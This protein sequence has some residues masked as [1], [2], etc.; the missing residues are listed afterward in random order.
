MVF[1]FLKPYKRQLILGPMAKL[2]EAVF[3]LFTPLLMASLIDKGVA[4]QDSGHVLRMSALIGV[5]SLVGFLCAAFCQYSASVA[6]QG[7]GT[8]LRNG[9]MKK[10]GLLN[11]K[12]MAEI[13]SVSVVNRL[14]GDVNQLQ[15]A[16]AMF[17]RLVVRA[18][19][20]CV[21][22]LIMA[23][24]MDV[25][26]SVILWVF[27]PLF[28][29]LLI[30]ITVKTIPMYQ[31]V[32]GR[33]D[34]LSGILKENITGVRV[35]R[36]FAMSKREEERFSKENDGWLFDS[37]KA[38]RL[39]ALLSPA[40][41]LIMNA[42]SLL[43][44]YFGGFHVEGG[45]LTQGQLIAFLSYV[46]QIMLAMIV[47]SNLAVLFHKAFAS[48]KRVE[49]LMAMEPSMAYGAGAQAKGSAVV[50]ENV[51][52]RYGEGAEPAVENVSFTV[53]EGA[54]VGIIGGTGAGKSSLLNL[55]PRLYDPF[56]GS[57]F[58]GGAEVKEYTREQLLEKVALVPQK[59]ALFSGTVLSNIRQGKPDATQEA[60][61]K[62]AEIAQA[63]EFIDRLPEKYNSPVSPGGANF[64][65]GQKQRLALARGLVGEKEVLIL[66]DS[67]SALDYA[68]D[69]SLR[70]AIREHIKATVFIA[71]QRISSVMQA[72]TILVM[73]DGRLV[74]HGSHGELLHNCPVYMDICKSQGMG[75]EGA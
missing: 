17:I 71:S 28:I 43:I 65:G 18:P 13:G 48:L 14:T 34:A 25:K 7:F 38:G 29:L 55:I 24:V 42:A 11:V 73:D 35:V 47:V 30:Y 50:F 32:R 19:F 15:L 54:I 72:D 26:L 46:T 36:A 68:T 2:M 22:G 63:K 12:D 49:A 58:I 74:G 5:V 16:V 6:S 69:L 70:M 1:R 60:I 53:A 67:A 45:Q 51:S 41:L 23:M 56:E 20:L 31:G 9:L 37:V 4:L 10:I 75:G 66:D 40:T 39:S 64:S 27:I 33:L 3:E 59:A 62:A 61:D 8:E 44:I 57:I 21:G 52:F